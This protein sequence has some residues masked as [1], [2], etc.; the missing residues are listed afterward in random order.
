MNLADYQKYIEDSGFVAGDK[1][2]YFVNWV[3]RYLRMRLSATLSDQD[4][5]KQFSESLSADESLED[6]R[7][8]Q[9]RQAV[10]LYVNMYLKNVNGDGEGQ[11]CPYSRLLDDMRNSLRLKH[12]SIRTEK[13]YL[14]WAGRYMRHCAER[15]EN[16]RDSAAVKRYLTYLAVDQKVASGTQNQAFNSILFFFRHAL[17]EELED[18][19][20]V[21]RAKKKRNIPAVLSVGEVK[22]LFAQVEGTRR[23]ILELIYGAGLRVS[24]LT[25]LRVMN[26]DF[27][28][29]HVV[30]KDG[31]GGKDRLVPLPRKLEDPLRAHFGKVKEMHDEDLAQGYGEVYLPPALNRKFSNAG[32]EWKW[33][34]VFPASKLAV[35]PRSGAVRRHHILDQTVQ[36][37]MRNAVKKAGIAKKATVHTLRHSFA[38]HLL[39]SGVNIREI[40][41]LLGHKNLET[42]MIYTHVVR[43]LSETPRSPLDMLSDD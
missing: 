7:R 30:V 26:I 3:K 6:W 18:I 24:E 16:F 21:V 13:T 39:M 40:Q 11:E 9:A 10:E 12:Y 23:M 38:T 41:E 35:D 29:H 8:D 14:D 43:E 5:V 36:K 15:G 37:I 20:N 33:Q 34:Y 42:T 28:N 2:R 31:K 17:G 4:K 27:D 19:R 22:S 32:R 25:R 1:S